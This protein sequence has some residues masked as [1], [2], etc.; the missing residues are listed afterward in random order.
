MQN[1]DNQKVYVNSSPTEDFHFVMNHTNAER[2]A[3]IFGYKMMFPS[4]V[5]NIMHMVLIGDD[6][7]C[8]R[9]QEVL[10]K[11]K[12]CGIDMHRLTYTMFEKYGLSKG[13]INKL[14]D[15]LLSGGTNIKV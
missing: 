14:T 6:I 3:D 5:K 1:Y 8:G 11:L 12:S 13:T 2:F 15:I 9:D 4:Y 7:K 10:R